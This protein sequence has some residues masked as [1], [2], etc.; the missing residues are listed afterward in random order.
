MLRSQLGAYEDS[1]D[2]VDALQALTAMNR[3]MGFTALNELAANAASKYVWK[4]DTCVPPPSCEIT[5]FNSNESRL[6]DWLSM[7]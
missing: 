7:H 4:V 3:Q 2:L 5:F 6:D 1:D